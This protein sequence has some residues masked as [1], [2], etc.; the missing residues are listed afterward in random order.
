MKNLLLL[1]GLII[2]FF[3]AHAQ[4]GRYAAAWPGINYKSIRVFAYNLDNQLL[5]KYQPVKNGQL[6]PTIVQ[7]GALLN[8]DQ[9]IRLLALLNGDTQV[10]NDGLAGCYEPH[11][12]IVFYDENGHIVASV[13][14]CFLCE[15]IRFYPA[16]KYVKRQAVYNKTT[17][18]QARE[19]GSKIKE[20]IKETNVPVFENTQEYSRF[21]QSLCRNQHQTIKLEQPIKSVVKSFSDHSYIIK[22]YKTNSQMDSLQ[23]T[24]LNKFI[25]TTFTILN[26][27]LKMV[28]STYDGIPTPFVKHILVKEKKSGLFLGFD[29]GSRKIEVYDAFK[30]YLKDF[31]YCSTL[32]I[33]AATETYIIHFNQDQLVESIEYLNEIKL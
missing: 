22:N 24:L 16:K 20:L 7:P 28:F 31:F 33:K 32:E 30:S 21:G 12:A 4:K 19:L 1:F 13:D 5:G 3:S 8:K 27:S 26:S 18:S 25:R 6:D 15:G 14:V 17:E 23:D 29:I 2:H 9:E 10:L 11:H